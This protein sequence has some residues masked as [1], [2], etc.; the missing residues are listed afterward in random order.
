[1]EEKEE[2]TS[3]SSIIKS[4]EKK[5]LSIYS[6]SI[7]ET[8]VSKDKNNVS[9]SKSTTDEDAPFST[10]L[11]LIPKDFLK[12]L[13]EKG[14]KEPQNNYKKDNKTNTLESSISL[15]EKV[16]KEADEI[17]ACAK[18]D[19][20]E[21]KKEAQRLLAES[22]KRAQEIESE[23]YEKGFSQGKKDGEEF[24]R[25]QFEAMT[26]RLKRLISTLQ[27][28]GSR[29]AEKYESQIINLCV[30]IASRV[31]KHEIETNPEVI[32]SVVKE[33]LSHVVE[34][35][36]LILHLN[37][38]DA[39]LIEE[40]FKDELTGPGKHKININSDPK[41]ERGGCLLETEFGLIDATT[42]TRLDAIVSSIDD[43][44][45]QTTGYKLDSGIV[46]DGRS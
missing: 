40:K 45:R 19:A 18:K 34:G 12:N 42:K 29:I 32:L 6:L 43:I 41:I 17:L 24:G 25:K 20:E 39:E 14:K 30:L 13:K 46:E 16:K 9:I 7:D 15:L 1:M 8:A 28:Q 33:A 38:I 4:S 5:E 10:L 2:T 31:I 3:L 21:L 23:A 27:D 11:D 22:R 26:N 36:S 44:L 37:P 35:T